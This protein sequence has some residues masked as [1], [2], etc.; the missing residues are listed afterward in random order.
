MD[1]R[2]RHTAHS[3]QPAAL[4]RGIIISSSDGG[5][6][7]DDEALAEACAGKGEVQVESSDDA[8]NV[9]S[10]SLGGRV[11]ASKAAA[12]FVTCRQSSCIL[13]KSHGWLRHVNKERAQCPT[14]ACLLYTSPSPRD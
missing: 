2:T 1:T 11:A 4:L 5:A 9:V 14:C 8:V 10:K 13:Y 3:S 6:N 12:G 7:S